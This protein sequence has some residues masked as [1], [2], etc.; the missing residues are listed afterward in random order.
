MQD[1]SVLVAVVDREDPG[2]L[3]TQRA[4]HLA[5]HAGQV[6][7]PGGRVEP[8]D[9]DAVHTALREAEEE[10]G[11]DGSFVEV[12]GTLAPYRTI[13]HYRVTPVLALVRPGFTLA[14]DA[15][16]VAEVFEVPLAVLRDPARRQRHSRE[17]AGVEVGYWV[18]EY[19]GR[20]VWGATAAMLVDLCQRLDA[21][22]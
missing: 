22:T 11:L 12:L 17:V 6:S 5:D 19:E 2:I 4:K 15:F 3:L 13:T 1:A 21:I 7:F 9:R 18:Y 20:S 16:E 14:A 8:S 10:I